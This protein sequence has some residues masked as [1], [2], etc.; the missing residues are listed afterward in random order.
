ME[1][2]Y[3]NVMIQKFIILLGVVTLLFSC[4]NS[5]FEDNLADN[6]DVNL[7][8][9][10]F[11]LS[12]DEAMETEMDYVPMSPSLRAQDE[13]T[14]QI[15]I[16]NMYKILV[17][18]K[19]GT[20]WIVNQVQTLRIDPSISMSG[21]YKVKNGEKITDFTMQLTPGEYRVT[22]ITGG[23]ARSANWN[24]DLPEG[25]I[26]DD[27]NDPTYKV[28]YF[29]TYKEIQPGYEFAGE[30]G[31]EEEIFSGVQGF[32]VEK[33]DDLHSSPKGTPI[34][35]KMKRMVS[36]LLVLLDNTVTSVYNFGVGNTN[37]IIATLKTTDPVGFPRGLNVWGEPYY[38][39]SSVL[40]EMRYI[41]YT[42]NDEENVSGINYLVTRRGSQ[43][44]NTY[45]FGDPNKNLSVE[46]SDID[47]RVPSWVGDDFFTNDII[48][49]LTLKNNY[50]SGFILK[51][52]NN[53]ILDPSGTVLKEFHV[54]FQS[55]TTPKSPVGIFDNN[56]EYR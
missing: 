6:P 8:E 53:E 32:T 55:G 22:V 19:V 28:P 54:D 17:S 15:V 4:Q 1:L 5:Q 7:Q 14:Y 45:Y 12:T 49:S 13:N 3:I 48:P 24:L 11:S 27:D 37:T 31:L 35:L 56:F 34:N 23:L 47:V 9:I 42:G 43:Q 51:S 38:D 20:K 52:G 46:I 25:T 44:F 50:I 21:W 16:T 33:T 36:K 26:I 18:K 10:R 2:K 29:C 30:L 40:N 41:V 39:S